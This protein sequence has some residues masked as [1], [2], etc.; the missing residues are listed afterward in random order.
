[1][2]V[3]GDPNNKSVRGGSRFERP[4]ALTSSVSR[5]TATDC[6]MVSGRPA[7]TSTVILCSHM[8]FAGMAGAL[9]N[10]ARLMTAP[11]ERPAREYRT[12]SFKLD[13]D[14][15]LKFAQICLMRL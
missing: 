5:R 6:Y 10:H 11:A 12:I 13:A 9:R 15:P 8:P 7:T 3:I 4:A 14:L 1:M 2:S